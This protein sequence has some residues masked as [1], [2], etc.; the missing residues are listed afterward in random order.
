[1]GVELELWVLLVIV[2][3]GTSIFGIFETETPRWRKLVKWPVFCGITV[4]LYYAIG[5]L[6]LAFPIGLLAAAAAYH[7]FWCHRHGIHPLHATPRRK[8]YELRGWRW[9]E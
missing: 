3:F 2:V 4:G 5:H 9:H 8:Y 6:A 1:M 7:I